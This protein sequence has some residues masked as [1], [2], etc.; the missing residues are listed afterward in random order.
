MIN[1]YDPLGKKTK[2]YDISTVLAGMRDPSNPGFA[3]VVTKKGIDASRIVKG[4]SYIDPEKVNALQAAT[5]FRGYGPK[6]ITGDDILLSGEK[7]LG[8]KYD[9]GTTSGD[10]LDC[11]LFTLKAFADVGIDLGNRQADWQAKLFSEKG[12]IHQDQPSPGDLV[13]YEKTYDSG[14][15]VFGDVTHVGIYAGNGEILHCGGRGGVCYLDS[16]LIKGGIVYVG[17]IE[18]AFGIKPGQGKGPGKATMDPNSAGSKAGAKGGKDG[19]GSAPAKPQ[20]PLER[21][22]S[23]YSE[24]AKNASTA[25]LTG[26]V[27]KGTPL[28]PP[29]SSGGKGGKGGTSSGGKRTNAGTGTIHGDLFSGEG[30]VDLF[31][32]TVAPLAQQEDAFHYSGIRPSVTIAQAIQESMWGRSDQAIQDANYFGIKDFPNDDWEGPNSV[33]NTREEYTPGQSTY[34]N[35]PFRK[36][37]SMEESVRDHDYFL[38]NYGLRGLSTEEQIDKLKENGYATA[39]NYVPELNAHVRTCDLKQYDEGFT[40]SG[41]GFI[42]GGAVQ[43]SGPVGKMPSLSVR[44]SLPTMSMFG[45]GD[46]IA[47]TIIS[48]AV[49]Q[50]KFEYKPS[51]VYS[52]DDIAPDYD[53]FGNIIAKDMPVNN[54]VTSE[55]SITVI[56][57]KQEWQRQWWASKSREDKEAIRKANQ[58]IQDAKKENS[59]ANKDATT[60]AE[61]AKKAAE[62][63]AKTAADAAKSSTATEQKVKEV[64]DNVKKELENK[65]NGTNNKIEG[66]TKAADKAIATMNADTASIVSAI[67]SLD[68]RSEVL[69]MIKYLQ[70]IAEKSGATAVAATKTASAATETAKAVAKSNDAA[71]AKKADSAPKTS[72][73]SVAA[74]ATAS[75]RNMSSQKAYDTLHALNLKIAKGGEFKRG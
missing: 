49:A 15:C 71:E 48:D 60:S 64:Y 66:V 38:R 74:N 52:D 75:S 73:A 26:Q 12:A 11:G 46:G 4:A 7:Y 17:S 42:G 36:Y 47:S 45:G 10:A 34:E 39:D 57:G 14:P 55:D 62:T 6:E 51:T 44:K 32:E 72:G 69:T 27:Y 5:I 35:A 1:I 41:L 30:G 18:K 16:G 8:T 21:F 68:I 50:K 65:I 54:K 63:T 25:M 19:K 61:E 2:G 29:K 70:V 59:E 24:A 33:W 67:K 20:N 58:A 53:E 3:S 31:V 56:E 13:F 23:Y 9:F 43:Q 40:G 28:D 22:L 37:G